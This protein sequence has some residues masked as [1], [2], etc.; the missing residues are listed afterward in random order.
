MSNPYTGMMTNVGFT[1]AP[2]NWA[3]CDG[4]LMS[5]AQNNALFALLGT[6]YGGDGQTTFGLPNLQGRRALHRGQSAGTSNY[7]QGQIGGAEQVTL[8]SSNLPAHTHSATF[9]NTSTLTAQTSKGQTNTPTA[10][11]QLAR[12]NDGDGDPSAVPFIYAPVSPGNQVALG[13]INLAGTNTVTN[14][15]A[16]SSQPLNTVTPYS[17][18]L[19]IICLFG[20]F[21]SRN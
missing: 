21:P 13:G 16:G 20:V 9:T 12:G 2:Q 17:T 19:T 11:Y 8:T 14:A 3:T 5:I 10:N 7:S 1:F 6:T 18:I 15:V 4:Q